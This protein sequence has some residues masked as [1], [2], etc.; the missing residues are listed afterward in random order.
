MILRIRELTTSEQEHLRN[1]ALDMFESDA[2]NN[3]YYA[4]ETVE[5][6]AA[7]KS[8]DWWLSFLS[9]EPD[10]VVQL[11]GFNPYLDALE[12]GDQQ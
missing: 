12:E 3:P 2:Y 5:F 4:R 6:L 9:S 8:I 10:M 1:A 7:D 11:L